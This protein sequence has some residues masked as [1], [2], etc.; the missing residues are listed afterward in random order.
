MHIDR[1]HVWELVEEAKGTL[2][3]SGEQ[4]K[5]SERDGKENSKG[6]REKRQDT[7]QVDFG[8][9]VEDKLNASCYRTA[10]AFLRPTGAR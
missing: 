8:C 3:S 9:T 10:P 6:K 2:C 4:R 5:E 1:Q 7:A